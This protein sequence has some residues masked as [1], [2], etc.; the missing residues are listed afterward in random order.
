MT[1]CIVHNL[2]N[3]NTQLLCVFRR[4]LFFLNINPIIS[5]NLTSQLPLSRLQRYIE[6]GIFQS[7]LDQNMPISVVRIIDEPSN[8]QTRILTQKG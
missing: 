6:N 3:S 8:H 5:I 1:D 4:I 2:E 7:D